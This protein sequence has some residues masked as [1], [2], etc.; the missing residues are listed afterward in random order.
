MTEL[1]SF[2]GEWGKSWFCD[3]NVLDIV[4]I[5]APFRSPEVVNL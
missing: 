3:H 1:S 4:S 2:F 5:L